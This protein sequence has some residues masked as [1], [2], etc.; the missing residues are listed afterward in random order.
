MLDCGIRSQCAV[1]AFDVCV[2]RLVVPVDPTG[3]LHEESDGEQCVHKENSI[4]AIP[5]GTSRLWSGAGA[6]GDFEG[7]HL[8][9]LEF[10]ELVKEVEGV[11]T[12]NMQKRGAR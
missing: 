9:H 6:G 11:R 3:R 10:S 2:D 1:D 7:L 4:L 8:E 12:R 5:R